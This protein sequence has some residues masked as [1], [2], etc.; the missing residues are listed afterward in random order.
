MDLLGVLRN[1][2]ELLPPGDYSAGLRAVLQHVQ[3]AVNH[4]ARGQSTGDDTSFTDAIY[5]TN[6]AFEGSLKE[7][8]RVLAAKEPDKLRTFDIEAYLQDQKLLRDRVLSQFS[9]Y[10][11]AWRNPSTHDHRLDF[12]EDEALL[13]IVSVC[14]FAIVL[15]DQIA[16]RLSFDSALAAAEPQARIVSGNRLPLAERVTSALMSFEFQHSDT[17]G[18]EPPREF[19]LVGAL[20]GYLTATFPDARIETRVL[21]HPKSAD[22][23]DLLVTEAAE[24]VVIETKRMRRLVRHSKLNFGKI[25]HYMSLADTPVGIVYVSGPPSAG[26]IKRTN[27]PVMGALDMVIVVGP[28][29][30]DATPA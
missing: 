2:I 24:R 27:L 17:P 9:A 23:T 15:V 1:R 25:L 16:E 18:G 7:A 6:Q 30:E 5:R 19:E 29:G 10:R 20:G 12:D 11:T 8:Y 21:L 28:E 26:Q 13:A 3:V 14:A 4:L 22:R